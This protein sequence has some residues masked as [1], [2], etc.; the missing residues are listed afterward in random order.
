M[1]CIRVVL[2][3]AV[4]TTVLPA[5]PSTTYAE[6]TAQDV[7][8]RL[9]LEESDQPM[10]EM[11]GWRAPEAVVVKV[12]GPDRLA[13]YQEVLPDSIALLPAGDDYEAVQIAAR[14]AQDVQAA[15]GFCNSDIVHAGPNIRWMQSFGAGV[16]Q[17]IAIPEVAEGDYIVT[18]TQHLAGPQIAEYVIATMLYFSRGLDHY[19]AAQ[20]ERTWNSF[21][22]PANELWAINTKTMFIAGL[23]GIGTEIARLA[24]AL[25]MRVIATRNTSREGPD[26]VDYVGLAHELPDLAA[27]A[28]VVVNA[29]PLTEATRGIFDAAL[30]AQMKP[31]TLFLNVGR[32]G[33]VVTEDIVAALKSGT[34]AGASLDVQDTEPLPRDHLLWDTPNLLITPHTQSL[35]DSG[36]EM[37]WIVLR[38]NLRRYVAGE[39]MLS[40]VDI[41]K[42]Y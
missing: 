12:D 19:S 29:M 39:K 30:F 24:D 4:M 23:G 6:L 14:N 16:S 36:R 25:G 7:I 34:I 15:V 3:F 1:S 31:T 38:E 26:F 5:I 20:A 32:G 33:T 13:W 17:C 35:Y 18:N 22:V 21:A 27:Q 9:A 28:D 42:G 2:F 10:R 41:D 40:V 37:H 8:Q 11:P